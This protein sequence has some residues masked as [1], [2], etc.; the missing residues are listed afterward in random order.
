MLLEHVTPT[1]THTHAHNTCKKSGR[2]KDKDQSESRTHSD[3]SLS[4][5]LPGFL[6]HGFSVL[7]ITRYDRPLCYLILECDGTVFCPED[8]VVMTN[9]EDRRSQKS[10]RRQKSY[11]CTC[12]YVRV[13][14]VLTRR[15]QFTLI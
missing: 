14:V 6:L 3:V 10:G 12:V 1:H 7:V 9:E 15:T 8:S 5:L 11:T 13:C 2:R 4:S